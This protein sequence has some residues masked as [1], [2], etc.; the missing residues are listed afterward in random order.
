VP[1]F[2]ATDRAAYVSGFPRD[3]RLTTFEETGLPECP[4]G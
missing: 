1:R 3:Q 4:T 2:T